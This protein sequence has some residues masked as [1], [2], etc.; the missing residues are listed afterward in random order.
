MTVL[1]TKYGHTV[2]T[3]FTRSCVRNC[4]EVA[5]F[6]NHYRLYDNAQRMFDDLVLKGELSC[7]DK[8]ES[9]LLVLDQCAKHVTD[10]KD[11]H[12]SER[13]LQLLANERVNRHNILRPK[14]VKRETTCM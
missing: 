2:W 1:A 8:A 12:P 7:S 10:F 6:K 9:L 5:Q 4:K 11:Y 14:F 13:N 3:E